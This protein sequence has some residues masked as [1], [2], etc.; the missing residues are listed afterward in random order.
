MND[1]AMR[2]ETG[3]GMAGTL[4]REGGSRVRARHGQLDHGST[5]RQGV[6]SAGRRIDSWAGDSW[7]GPGAM[8]GYAGP[9]PPRCFF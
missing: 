1:Y 9:G 8:G 7:A 6:G 2:A 5:Q 3:G 4:G